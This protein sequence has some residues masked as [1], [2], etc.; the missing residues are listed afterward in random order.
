MEVILDHDDA[1]H[2]EI[3]LDMRLQLISTYW[4]INYPLCKTIDNKYVK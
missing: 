2:D 4:S 1:V 3:L